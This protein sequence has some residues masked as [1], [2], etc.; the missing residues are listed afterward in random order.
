MGY[1]A[2]TEHDYPRIT[3]A[4][5]ALI[6][7]N[8]AI[9]FLQWTVVS[10]ADMYAAMGWKWGN[11]ESGRWWTALTYM[12]VH[13]GF[14]HMAGN[15]YFLYVFG[16][17]LE[18]EWG[19]R[20]FLRFYLL[21]GL[22]GLA[23]HSL[24]IRTGVL[25][26]ASAAVYGVMGAYALRWPRDEV[27]FFGI[28]P[29]RVWTLV[30]LFVTYDLLMGLYGTGVGGGTNV[31]YLAHVG[32][33][34]VAW[35]YS[36]TPNGVSLEQLRQRMA[37]APDPT[38]EPPRA[39]PRQPRTRERLDE[40]DEIVAKSKAAVAKRPAPAVT[41]RPREATREELNALLDKISAH[42]MN[43]LSADERR[44]LDEASKKLRDS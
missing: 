8:C 9:L 39:I 24:F 38:D 19:T 27:Y 37:Q 2:A 30:L 5:Q 6:A 40:V 11:V 18:H 17:R 26:G 44:M 10:P 31:A 13:G 21:A 32:G 7:I 43:S 25:F 16:P 35:F 34:A 41:R 14:W 1:E 23:A 29:M 28:V 20:R 22:G 15:A 42:G 33:F 12:F 3:P 4:V 36:R